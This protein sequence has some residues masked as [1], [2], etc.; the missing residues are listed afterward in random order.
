M[1][2]SGGSAYLAE[3]D[4]ERRMT[5]PMGDAPTTEAVGDPDADSEAGAVSGGA[6]TGA[7]LGAAVAGPI[8]LVVGAALGSVAGTAAEPPDPDLEAP[9]DSPSTDRPRGRETGPPAADDDTVADPNV[10]AVVDQVPPR[11]RAS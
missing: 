8:G 5:G 1:S 10:P 9:H 6:A 11:T 3:M 7:V 2:T 4:P